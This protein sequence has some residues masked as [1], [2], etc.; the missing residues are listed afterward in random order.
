M[1]RIGYL[2]KLDL[3]R[4]S[5]DFAKDMPSV[6]VHLVGP[7][8]ELVARENLHP[9]LSDFLIEA[10]QQ[11]HSSASLFRKRGEFPALLE[12]EFRISQDATRYY[13]SGK[14]Y[15]YRTFPFWL[16]R[17]INRMI[18]AILPVVL[19]LIP[20]LKIIP[21]VYRWRMQARIYRWYR[22]LLELEREAFKLSAD[23]EQRDKLLIR[24][25]EIDHSVRKIRVPAMFADLFYGLREHIVFVRER[26]ISEQLHAMPTN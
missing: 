14:S 13:A 26:L 23:A 3:P 11:V 15:L 6:D 9:A 7:T 4:G 2:N 25:A 18:V 1:R 10:A 22:E 19:I 8:V 21:G 12:H 20:G 16:A 5:L 17:T 24:L